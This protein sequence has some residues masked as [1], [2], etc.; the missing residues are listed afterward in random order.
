MRVLLSRHDHGSRGHLRE[1]SVP[2]RQEIREGLSGNLCR[3]SGYQKI[4]DAV[5]AVARCFAKKED[6]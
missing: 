3:C 6:L 2:A 4:V 1:H 5:E